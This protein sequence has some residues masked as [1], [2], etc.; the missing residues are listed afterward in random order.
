MTVLACDRAD[1]QAG[2]HLSHYPWQLYVQVKD[3]AR[4]ILSSLSA[5]L[6]AATLRTMDTPLLGGG[7]ALEGPRSDIGSTGRKIGC[8]SIVRVPSA[9]RPAPARLPASRHKSE[10]LLRNGPRH[11]VYA[12]ISHSFSVLHV[13]HDPSTRVIPRDAQQGTQRQLLVSYTATRFHQ[14]EA[15]QALSTSQA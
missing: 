14:D 15:P 2:K 7:P 10:S 1:K 11:A 3:Q 4:V 6:D 8:Y 9:R 12:G 13:L 5:R